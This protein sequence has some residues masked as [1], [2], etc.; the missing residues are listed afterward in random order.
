VVKAGLFELIRDYYK[1]VRVTDKVKIEC[2]DKGIKSGHRDAYVIDHLIRIG[3]IKVIK[4]EKDIEHPS[5]DR[6]DQGERSTI[7]EAINEDCIAVLN[8][9]KSR[10]VAGL[11]NVKFMALELLLIEMLA[12]DTIDSQSFDEHVKRLAKVSRMRGD[13]L[14]EVFE[15]KRIVLEAKK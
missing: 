1:D 4:A 9:Q 3:H 2:V 15:L 7:V 13:R 14:V 5:L 11:F 6:I 10:A 8:D 12:K